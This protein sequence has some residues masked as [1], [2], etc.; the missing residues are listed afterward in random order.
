MYYIGGMQCTGESYKY[1]FT[2]SEDFWNNALIYGVS[3]ELGELADN[4]ETLTKF[5]ESLEGGTK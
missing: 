3:D 2:A 1:S 5:V 4:S